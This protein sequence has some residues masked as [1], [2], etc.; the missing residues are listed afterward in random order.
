[1]RRF[2]LYQSGQSLP[3]A[4]QANS[5]MSCNRQNTERAREADEF[6]QRMCS[7][8]RT[9][10]QRPQAADIQKIEPKAKVQTDTEAGKEWDNNVQKHPAH[11]RQPLAASSRSFLIFSRVV[12]SG[13]W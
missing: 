7:R 5:A 6:E 3:F 11:G 13:S 1:M 10:H 4:H 8:C 9:I 12:A 2:A